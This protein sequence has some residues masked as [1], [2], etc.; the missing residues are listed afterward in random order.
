MTISFGLTDGV[1][2]LL[3]ATISENST[4]TTGWVCDDYMHETAAIAIC[5]SINGSYW[6]YADYQDLTDEYDDILVNY[7]GCSGTKNISSQCTWST[8]FSCWST[9]GV[10]LD[11]GGPRDWIPGPLSFT[12]TNGDKGWLRTTVLNMT[13]QEETGW[14]CGTSFGELEG[15]AFCSSMFGPNTFWTY[16]H[17]QTLTPDTRDDF[18][19]DNIICTGV[20]DIWTQCSW[21]T[22][23]WC[24]QGERLY[25][26]CGGD[27]A[28]PDIPNEANGG[29]SQGFGLTNGTTGILY[30]RNGW[31]CDDKFDKDS[32][33]IV[34]NEMGMSLS[35]GNSWYT[36][37]TTSASGSWNG[38]YGP[39]DFGME[40]LQC[41]ETADVIDDC[42]WET[43]HD[44]TFMEGLYIN[45]TG[46]YRSPDI[47]GSSSNITQ[48]SV[49]LIIVGIV[50]VLCIFGLYFFWIKERDSQ[51]AEDYQNNSGDNLIQFSTSKEGAE[52][53]ESDFE[54]TVDLR[55]QELSNELKKSELRR[56]N[57]KLKTE[58]AKYKQGS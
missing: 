13:N 5:N 58:L 1:I 34:C 53:G 2:G 19:L 52:Y 27:R 12:L 33:R 39:T 7:I 47:T 28:S 37:Y 10:Y 17:Q 44:C 55:E 54:R 18:E 6:F 25:L 46:A 57:E 3:Y 31:V 41:N 38:Y 32:A 48:L 15:E 50:V 35:A 23:H 30:M 51:G 24:W 16:G 40:S 43:T 45:C 56:E 4:N 8:E 49:L 11:C 14:V 29:N 36:I 22:N 42:T 20:E 26:D 9:K 21:R